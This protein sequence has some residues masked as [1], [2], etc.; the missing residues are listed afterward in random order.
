[1]T[2]FND[3]L[4]AR[5]IPAGTNFNTLEPGLWYAAISKEDKYKSFT[6]APPYDHKWYGRP[7]DWS[8]IVLCIPINARM[9]CG[10]S[11]GNMGEYPLKVN[12]NNYTIKNIENL[13][14]NIPRIQFAFN[15]DSGLM[16]R[17]NLYPVRPATFSRV[18]NNST[19]HP[20]PVIERLAYT[21]WK[22][23]I[24]QE[25]F[26]WIHTGSFTLSSE[27]TS[28]TS[29]ILYV[30]DSFNGN[31]HKLYLFTPNGCTYVNNNYENDSYGPIFASDFG[32]ST[33][34]AGVYNYI[35]L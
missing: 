7:K 16:W 17:T 3:G 22:A 15:P 14:I 28:A 35:L 2:L 33:F 26:S 25:D 31:P 27:S 18:T 9:W 12:P 34:P 20:Y 4:E 5:Q 24:S 13:D 32:L 19:G 8:V 11:G 23:I 10:N 21:K 6:N 1:M 29:G 30:K